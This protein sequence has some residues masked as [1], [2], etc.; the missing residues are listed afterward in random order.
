MFGAE[1][2]SDER[3]LAAVQGS[4]S[5]RD[6]ILESLGSQVR[7]MVMARLSPTPA[8]FHAVDD[9]SQRSLIA[10]AEGMSRLRSPTIGALKSYTSTIVSRKVADYI[11]DARKR[12]QQPMAS[13]DSTVFGASA[14]G[15]LVELLST[16]GT[17]PL[18][19]MARAEAIRR[20]IVDLG[21][22]KPSHR[23]VITL[24]FFDQ[25]P[26]SEIAERLDKSR[27]AVSMLLIR[28]IKTLRRNVT[29]SSKVHDGHVRET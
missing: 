20:I 22:L 19:S 12:K 24:A 1:T 4:E 18:S 6:W 8:Q 7:T 3:I 26:L 2:I 27:P 14:A 23:E 29:G 21:R 17:S 15:S 13:L 11:R 28:A 16:S 10:L 25:L 5:D 9:I